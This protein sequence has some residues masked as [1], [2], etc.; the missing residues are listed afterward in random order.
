MKCSGCYHEN[1]AWQKICTF[2]GQATASLQLC[3]SGHLL[4]PKQTDCAVCPSLWPDSSPFEGP[5]ILRGVL[6]V[7]HGRLRSA[8]GSQQMP[9]VELRDSEQPMSFLVTGAGLAQLS[10]DSDA[11]IALKVEVRPGGTRY[12]LGPDHLAQT[13]QGLAYQNLGGE[14]RFRVGPVTFRVLFFPVPSWVR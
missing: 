9:F 12:C 7:D 14:E 8:D 11:E 3:P 13:G 6:W 10:V 1:P 2:C 4:M 5:P